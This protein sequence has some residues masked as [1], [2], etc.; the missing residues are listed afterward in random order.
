MSARNPLSLGGLFPDPEDQQ[1][2]AVLSNY[3]ML[4]QFDVAQK[5]IDELFTLDPERIIRLFRVMFNEEIPA[6][7]CVAESLL[8]LL[9]GT[10]RA[11][12][13]FGCCLKC[14]GYCPSH[15]H[16][17]LRWSGSA[18]RSTSAWASLSN[19]MWLGRCTR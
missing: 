10:S 17:W 11:N 3:L 15:L 2:F 19:K 13:L 6:T 8:Y 12:V 18:L 16:R 5:V 9:T 4:S 14:S 7:W 1:I